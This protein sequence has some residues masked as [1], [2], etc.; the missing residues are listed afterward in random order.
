MSDVLHHA[1]TTPTQAHAIGRHKRFLDTIRANAARVPIN[2]ATDTLKQQLRDANERAATSEAIIAEMTQRMDDHIKDKQALEL[3]ISCLRAENQVLQRAT[4]I[5]PS[6]A[7]IID[8]VAKHY[9]TT[10]ELILSNQRYAGIITARHVAAYIACQTVTSLSLTEMGRV[11]KR[12][13]SSMIHA[14]DKIVAAME[15][16]P[17][18]AETVKTLR[19]QINGVQ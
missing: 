3:R 9:G 12:D 2:D 8:V 14:R 15:A 6:V 4:G 18:L 10:R 11:F 13:H 5:N 16:D 17:A 1:R 7:N 19:N